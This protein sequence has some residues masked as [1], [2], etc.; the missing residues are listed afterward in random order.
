MI[1]WALQAAA[2]RDPHIR[3]FAPQRDLEALANLVEVAFGED[4]ALTGSHMVRDLRQMALAGPLLQ[5]ARPLADFLQGFVWTEDGALVGNVSVNQRAGA[6]VM[7][8]V[9]VLPEHRGRGIAGQ[10]V[11]AAIAHVR[12]QGGRR[13]LLQ[14]RSDNTPAQTLYARRG[15]VRFD[16]WHELDLA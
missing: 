7:T 9:A 3:P 8:N 5:F 15:F 6:W 4:L 2:P 16:S 14:V 12:R 11:D 10:L 13:I 1:A